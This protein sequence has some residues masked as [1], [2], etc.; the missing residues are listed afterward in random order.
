[1]APQSHGPAT[2]WRGAVLFD[3]DGTLVDSA[4]VHALAWWQAFRQHRYD[5]PMAAIHWHIGMGG[6]RLVDSLLPADRDKTADANIMASHAAVFA[7]SWPSLRA[8]DGAKDLLAQCHAGGLAV[9]LASSARKEDLAASRNALGAD[10]FIHAAT[11]ANDAKEGKPAPD[12]LVAALEAVGATPAGAVYVGDA[13]WD[14]KAAAALGM[15]SI[16]VTCGGRSAAELL[17]AGAAKVYAGPRDLLNNLE[18]SVIGRLLE[19]PG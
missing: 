16:G 1:M 7:T 3:V 14:M 9:A 13:V 6:D 2:W 11:S 8:L 15:P 4:Y 17:D 10:A 19:L 12:I 18:K 5:V